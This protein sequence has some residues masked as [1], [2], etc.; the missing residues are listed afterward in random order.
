MSNIK[1]PTWTCDI[2]D[3]RVPEQMKL[4]CI[5]DFLQKKYPSNAD[6]E[7][8]IKIDGEDTLVKRDKAEQYMMNIDNFSDKH[9]EQ[10]KEYKNLG[11]KYGSLVEVVKWTDQ[12]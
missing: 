6:F 2:A 7:L 11:F 9:K 8:S 3:T 1:G 10:Y 4:S 12:T 5:F